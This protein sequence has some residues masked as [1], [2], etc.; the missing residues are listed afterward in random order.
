MS[1]AAAMAELLKRTVF[2]P[3]ELGH[4]QR[5][6]GLGRWA[7]SV[8]VVIWRWGNRELIRGRGGKAGQ[9]KSLV[10]LRGEIEKS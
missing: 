9:G 5:V 8:K 2:G 6:N 1:S 7:V 4:L 3:G 10:L